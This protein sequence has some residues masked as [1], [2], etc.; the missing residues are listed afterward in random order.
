MD[1]SL[2]ATKSKALNFN[3]SF[4]LADKKTIP[5]NLWTHGTGS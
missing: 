2:I 5:T 1:S 3:I 4:D